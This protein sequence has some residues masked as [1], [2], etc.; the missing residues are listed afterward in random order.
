MSVWF[1]QLALKLLYTVVL[2][3]CLLL[4]C[5]IHKF[6]AKLLKECITNILCTIWYIANIFAYISNFRKALTA[7]Y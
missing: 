5:N 7:R 6:C 3:A 1:P 2:V 4:A